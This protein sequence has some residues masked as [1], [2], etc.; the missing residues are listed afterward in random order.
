MKESATEYYLLIPIRANTHEGSNEIFAKETAVVGWSDALIHIL[1]VAAIRSKGVAIGANAAE[2]TSHVMT[3]EGTLMT[4]LLTFIDIF[5]SLQE[6]RKSLFGIIR[7]Y[8]ISHHTLM[9][10]FW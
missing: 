6:R 10:K 2:C 5:T 3:T 7:M 4:Q 1:A 9:V 8:C